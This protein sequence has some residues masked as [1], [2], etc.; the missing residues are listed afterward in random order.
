VRGFNSLAAKQGVVF[1]YVEVR[2]DVMEDTL[3]QIAA[4]TEPLEVSK[5]RDVSVRR[6]LKETKDGTLGRIDGLSRN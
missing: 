2:N 6:M 3:R 1:L 4:L 5:A